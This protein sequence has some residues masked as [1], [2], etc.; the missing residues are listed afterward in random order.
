[1]DRLALSSGAKGETEGAMGR[2]EAAICC[3]DT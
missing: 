2:G 3:S 1:M